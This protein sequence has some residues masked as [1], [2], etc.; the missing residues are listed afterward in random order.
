MPRFGT[1][2]HHW[3]FKLRYVFS[4][5]QRACIAMGPGFL[6]EVSVGEGIV[7]NLIET[8][9]SLDEPRHPCLLDSDFLQTWCEGRC[10]RAR[11][12]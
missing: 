4:R 3:I 6:E 1:L 12:D 10:M 9:P 11:D 5:L 7:L 8:R 2:L